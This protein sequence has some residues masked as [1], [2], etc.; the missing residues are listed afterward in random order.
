[1]N[2]SETFDKL[3]KEEFSHIFLQSASL[4]D[5]REEIA[6]RTELNHEADMLCSLKRVK[7][8][9]N[10]RM[11]ALLQDAHLKLGASSLVDL[12]LESLL[13]H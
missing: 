2:I 9:D 8:A 4:L 10:V 5:V 1:M 13:A 6:S 7:K 12:T 3:L 11:V